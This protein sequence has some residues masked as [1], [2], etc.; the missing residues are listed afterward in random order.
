MPLPSPP[1]V[2]AL[3]E[4]RLRYAH[5]VVERQGVRLRAFRQLALPPDSY[6]NGML[7]GPL[8][9]PGAFRELVGALV[10]ALPGGV[11]GASLVVPDAWLRVTYS[12][13]GDL[14]RPG[15]ALDEVLRWKLR[16]LVPFRVDEL[17]IGAAEVSPLP[18]QEEPRRLLM[19]FAIE[20]LLA[21]IEDAFDAHGVRLG[22]I[23]NVS[24]SLLEAVGPGAASAAG[25]A[26]PLASAARGRSS[27]SSFMALALVEEYGYTLI[28]ARRGEPVLHRYK[29]TGGGGADT[30]SAPAS[31]AVVR[32]LRLT[33]NFL[34]EHFPGSALE[35]VLLLAPAPL[36]AVWLDRLQQGLGRRASVVNGATLPP[37]RGE[38]F[39][40]VP[41]WRELAPMIGAARRMIA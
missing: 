15:P 30:A 25:A 13:S 12:E 11:R 6:Q 14:P 22:H 8:R 18:G 9:D 3:D 17:R 4:E 35:T 2:F 16:R 38:G 33:R 26:H 20:Q 1:H 21:Q 23:G 27:A 5:L 39:S 34:D 29:A 31:A 41:P 10:E 7:G 37:V 40:A 28:F 24:L 36:E 19:G 32:D